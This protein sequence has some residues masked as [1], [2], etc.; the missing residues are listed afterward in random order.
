VKYRFIEA[1]QQ[2]FSVAALCRVLRVCRSGYYDW[3]R[4]P[5]PGAR[6][7]S[8]QQL[9][10]EIRRVHASNYEA[11][12][13]LKTWRALKAQG[14]AGGKHR[15]AR[16]RSQA[17]IE[18][19]RKRRFRIR[20]EHHHTAPPAPDLINRCFDAQQPNQAWVADMTFVRTR[21]GWLYLTTLL[22][23]FSRRIVGWA[24]SARP[25]E[26]LTLSALEMAIAS[27]RPPPGLIHHTDQGVIYRAQ[28]Y[29]RR[30]QVAGMRPSMGGRG[31][32]YDNAVA[33]SFF[34]TLKNEL[35][36]ECD[37]ETRNAARAAIFS[38]IE[39]FYNRRRLHQTL[40]YRSPQQFE[41][42]MLTLD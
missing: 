33:E 4:R 40:G 20:S 25:D 6:A 14:I 23:L 38:Y 9:L 30:L 16:L 26:A 13:A 7:R 28:R 5:Q 27:R 36:H 35:V 8:D 39:L 21:E 18:A 17:G 29:R 3:C 10:L 19:R 1:E 11:F 32:A 37:F 15:V 22:D 31:S 34:S 41:Q 24:M 2:Q 12:G 42:A